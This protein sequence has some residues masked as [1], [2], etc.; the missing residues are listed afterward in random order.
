MKSG[1]RILVV[2]DDDVN[3]DLLCDV[4]ESHGFDVREA[5]NGE[6]A[7]AARKEYKPHLA[8]VDLDMPKMNGIEFTQHVKKETPQFPII[9]ITGY[10]KFYS[11][12]DILASGVDAFLQKPLDINKLLELVGQL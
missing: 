5:E 4:L 12:E 10:A 6:E 3:R 7:V 1:S 9:M 8:I 11:P 2:D